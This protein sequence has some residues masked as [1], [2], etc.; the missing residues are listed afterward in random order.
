MYDLCKNVQIYIFQ[1][2]KKIDLVSDYLFI[3]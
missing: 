1:N 3:T 2:R